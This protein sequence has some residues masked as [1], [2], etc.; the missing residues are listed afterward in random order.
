MQDTGAAVT[1]DTA[2]AKGPPFLAGRHDSM[3]R[4]E[5]FRRTVGAVFADGSA[6]AT[7]RTVSAGVIFCG[8]A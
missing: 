6:I 4:S 8:K 7:A 2:N 5:T 1:N 3:Q